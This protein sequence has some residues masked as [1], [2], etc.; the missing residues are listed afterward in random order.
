MII[1][2]YIY[3]IVEVRD[4]QICLLLNDYIDIYQ[5]INIES[6]DSHHAVG[7]T[8]IYPYGVELRP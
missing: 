5:Y 3:I 1:Y 2:I 7:C 4:G 6:M 8:V